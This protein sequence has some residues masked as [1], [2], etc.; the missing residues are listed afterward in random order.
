MVDY[1]L[2][3]L[4]YLTPTVKWIQ[5]RQN[6]VKG[7]VDQNSSQEISGQKTFTAPLI[8]DKHRESHHIVNYQG[9]IY[10]AVDP[11]ILDQE[12]N[13]RM[14]MVEGSLSTQQYEDGGWRT[15]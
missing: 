2:V 12:G 13:A 14:G 8:I 10:W 11:A 6:K 1:W 7:A 15:I 9:F 5:Y 4:R 3:A